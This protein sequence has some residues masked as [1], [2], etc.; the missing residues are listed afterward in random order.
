L[1]EGEGEQIEC[2]RDVAL[3]GRSGCLLI[4]AVFLAEAVTRGWCQPAPPAHAIEEPKSDAG[5]H[6][7][8][9][10]EDEKAWRAWFMKD[11]VGAFTSAMFFVV[12]GQAG[13]FFV[14]FALG[15]RSRDCGHDGG[16]FKIVSKLHLPAG[17]AIFRR[18]PL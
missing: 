14:Q 2:C 9:K 7:E 5:A 10:K 1:E 16:Q 18:V 17:R 6:E 11:A 4:I 3:A 13:L 15:Y 8:K 12:L